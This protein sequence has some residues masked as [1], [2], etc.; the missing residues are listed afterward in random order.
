MTASKFSMPYSAKD[1]RKTDAAF[2]EDVQS[3]VF[4][5]HKVFWLKNFYAVASRLC[6]LAEIRQDER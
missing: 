3:E 2:R 6:T 4:L 5:L 1:L